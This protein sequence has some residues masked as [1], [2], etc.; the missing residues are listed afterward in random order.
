MKN[1]RTKIKFIAIICT[2]VL[3][4]QSYFFFPGSLASAQESSREEEGLFVAKKA[5]ED[6]FYEVSLGLLERFLK[7]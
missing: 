7:N 3:L 1:K 2:A 4:A 6:G 5:F